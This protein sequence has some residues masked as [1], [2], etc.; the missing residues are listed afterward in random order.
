[1]TKNKFIITAL[2]AALITLAPNA[3]AGI[4]NWRFNSITDSSSLVNYCF[5]NPVGWDLEQEN[6]VFYFVLGFMYPG[7]DSPVL[8]ALLNDKIFDPNGS[9]ILGSVDWSKADATGQVYVSLDDSKWTVSEWGT[10]LVVSTSPDT[11]TADWY[12][13]PISLPAPAPPG[14]YSEGHSTVSP[15]M[16]PSGGVFGA[17]IT[18]IPEPTTGLL[19][20][21]GAALL[22]L[23]RKRRMTE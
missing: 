12:A 2:A 17:G 7:L 21:G 3:R 6:T 1:M 18:V 14:G 9:Q 15:S 16:D 4:T 13:V 19:V 11:G 8:N 22:L 20:L 10:I 5:E 23:R